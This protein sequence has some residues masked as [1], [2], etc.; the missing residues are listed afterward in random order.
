MSGFMMD[1]FHASSSFPT[2]NWYWSDKSPPIYMFCSDMW[3]DNFIPLVYELCDLFCGSMYFKFFKD[4]APA[5][6]QGSR[7]LISVYGD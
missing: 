4:D 1:A 7:E 6:S 3:D 2:L 5:F